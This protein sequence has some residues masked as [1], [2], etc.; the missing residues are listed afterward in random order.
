MPCSGQV[1]H[2]VTTGGRVRYVVDDDNQT[3]WLMSQS[4]VGSIA[5]T[6]EVE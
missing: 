1:R 3:A 5:L 4:T 6:E 2:E